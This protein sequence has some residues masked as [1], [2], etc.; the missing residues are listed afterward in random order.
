MSQT[1]SSISNKKGKKILIYNDGLKYTFGTKQRTLA[2]FIKHLLS[3]NPTIAMIT[4]VGPAFAVGGYAIAQACEEIGI[5]Y[6]VSLIG[7]KKNKYFYKLEQTVGRISIVNNSMRAAYSIEEQYVD[8][9]LR[10]NR[11]NKQSD[12]SR[13]LRTYRINLGA[14]HQTYLDLLYSDMVNDGVLT[15]LNPTRVWLAVGSGV[16]L[17]CLLKLWRN[18][19]FNCVFVS[20]KRV[21][22]WIINN[23]RIRIYKST[24]RPSEEAVNVP[25]PTILTYDGKIW[26]FVEE[27]GMDGDVI[28]NIAT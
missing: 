27:N 3:K 2:L 10:I 16:I 12:N 4:Y 24:L 19:E 26:E 21:P 9:F 22:D 23:K 11:E 20:D 6:F 13:G 25:Y 5:P 18:A 14:M 1:L 17:S 28:F 8:E 15:T 7:T